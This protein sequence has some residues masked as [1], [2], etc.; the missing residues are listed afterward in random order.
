M[1]FVEGA[2]DVR[3]EGIFERRDPVAQIQKA[4]AMEL[5]GSERVMALITPPEVC[6]TLR[7]SL[8]RDDGKFLNRID[9][10]D[11]RQ[12]ALTGS[13]ALLLVCVA[14]SIDAIIILRERP[15]WTAT[16]SAAASAS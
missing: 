4:G 12:L 5:V 14:D 10:Q 9:G 8:L 6:R 16:A 1:V 15:R 3:I 2:N 11:S 7:S 13:A